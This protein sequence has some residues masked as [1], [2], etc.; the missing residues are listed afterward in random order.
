MGTTFIEIIGLPGSGKSTLFKK[1]KESNISEK[2]L[3]KKNN[4]I[5]EKVK[6]IFDITYDFFLILIIIEFFIDKVHLKSF[7]TIFKRILKL[8]L[9][10]FNS[11]KISLSIN[12]NK[13]HESLIHLAIDSNKKNISK[14]HKYLLKIYRTE[15]IKLIYLKL[16]P[17]EALSRMAN[18]GDKMKYYEN[19]LYQRYVRSSILYEEL[20]EYIYKE[21]KNNVLIINSKKKLNSHEEVI[22]W[23]KSA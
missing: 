2:Y 16:T 5:V 14:L 18:R 3:A 8:N 23:L 1:L 13:L 10:L 19:Q 20:I 11:K 22:N 17:E 15:K 7:I 12:K 6:L 9:V 21:N 4:L